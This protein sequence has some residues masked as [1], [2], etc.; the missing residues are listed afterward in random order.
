[1]VERIYSGKV[2]LIFNN[3]SLRKN[4]YSRKHQTHRP[5]RLDMFRSFVSCTPRYIFEPRLEAYR[6]WVYVGRGDKVEPQNSYP[7]R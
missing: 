5:Q 3:G 2:S 1:M 6:L 7:I 4:P